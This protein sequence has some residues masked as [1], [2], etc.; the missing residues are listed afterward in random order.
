[1]ATKS[2][3]GFD[4]N[5]TRGEIGLVYWL[6]WTGDTIAAFD[7]I[8]TNTDTTIASVTATVGGKVAVNVVL[9]TGTVIDRTIPTNDVAIAA[10]RNVSTISNAV[11]A[12]TTVVS[13][14]AVADSALASKANHTCTDSTVVTISVT[15]ITSQPF[16]SIATSV[17]I[18][19]NTIAGIFVSGITAGDSITSQ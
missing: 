10:A 15:A 7:V 9:S 11:V 5:D 12:F 14:V 3:F 13:M 19:F 17:T 1:M 6:V 18:S 4:L 16:I 2:A 8:Y